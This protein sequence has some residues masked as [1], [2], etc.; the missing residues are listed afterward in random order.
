MAVL[1]HWSWDSPRALLRWSLSAAWA[2]VDYTDILQIDSSLA[3]FSLATSMNA[4]DPAPG[5]TL[6]CPQLERMMAGCAHGRVGECRI[7]ESSPIT[8]KQASLMSRKRRDCAQWLLSPLNLNSNVLHSDRNARARTRYT[9]S[10][11]QLMR[12]FPADFSN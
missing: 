1:H 2:P 3:R 9:T 5:Q 12:L 8:A 10:L 6:S 11:T 4:V 7:I